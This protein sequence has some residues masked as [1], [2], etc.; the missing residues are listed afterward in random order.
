MAI[1]NAHLF[2]KAEEVAVAAERNRLAR[3]LHDAVTQTLFSASL[4]A[5][6]LPRI[7]ERDPDQG[8]L[9]LEELRG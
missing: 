9:R 4:I 5:D 2:E 7:W 1:E 8:R 3:E 6:V